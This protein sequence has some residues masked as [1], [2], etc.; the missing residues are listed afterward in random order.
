VSDDLENVRREIEET[1]LA[2]GNKISRLE[3][4]IVTTKNTTLNPAYHVKKRPWPT[5]A[6]IVAIGWLLGHRFVT[7]SKRK[8]CKGLKNRSTERHATRRLLRN[9]GSP[10]VSLLGIAAATM[11]R[12]V[13]RARGITPPP[14]E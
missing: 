4:K 13:V 7:P 1:R 8:I 3:D 11:I 14:S 9:L 10:L 2:L 5:L 12:N 6:T